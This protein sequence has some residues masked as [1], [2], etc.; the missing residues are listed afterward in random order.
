MISGTGVKISGGMVEKR[1]VKKFGAVLDNDINIF[2]FSQF[3]IAISRSRAAQGNK[4]N[5]CKKMEWAIS[6]ILYPAVRFMIISLGCRSPGTSSNLPG[7][8]GRAAL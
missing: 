4:D 1:Y 7:N 6:R 2:D 5:K 8:I 3:F